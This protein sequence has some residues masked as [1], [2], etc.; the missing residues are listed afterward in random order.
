MAMKGKL[1]MKLENLI[2]MLIGI[3][4]IWLLPNARALSPAPDGAYP[5]GNTA[6]GQNALF[7][8]TTGG[9]NTAVGFLSL[10]SN[11]T[12]QLNTAIGAGTLLANTSDQNTATGVGALLSNT[13]GPANTA[14]GAFALLSNTI[15]GGNTAI[16]VSALVN[17]TTGHGNIALGPTAGVNVTTA[18][19]VIC[20][21]SAGQNVDNSCYIA[22]IFGQ[23]VDPAT[24]APVL[25]DANGKLG[26]VASSR[27]FKKEIK[28]MDKTSEAILAL[29]PV[30]FHYK[31]DNTNTPQFGLIAEE[32][33][34]VNPRPGGAR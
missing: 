17:N 31:S 11:A 24:L 16:G 7:S 5:G 23:S 20:I 29:K 13:I 32:V 25:V 6:E 26:N 14:N 22:F 21:G 4:C 34:A 12:G 2:H 8:L 19:N 15:G 27:R 28:S 10:R 18:S 33:A 30:T 1:N 3:V 9:F